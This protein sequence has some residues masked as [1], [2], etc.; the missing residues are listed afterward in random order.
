M[1]IIKPNNN[2]ISAITALPSGMT[3]APGLTTG[4]LVLLNTQTVSNVAEVFIVNGSSGVVFDNTYKSYLIK[5]IDCYGANDGVNMRAFIGNSSDYQTSSYRMMTFASRYNG[6]SE[7]QQNHYS[8]TKFF[9]TAQNVRNTS[10]EYMQFEMVIKGA[11]YSTRPSSYYRATYKNN[12]GEQ[13]VETGGSNYD[14]TTT[15]TKIKF[16]T[17][18]GNIYGTFSLYGI[19][20]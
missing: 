19:K 10:P 4:S 14:A 3:S 11:G 5:I 7:A 9:E 8:N 12:S 2:T 16:N 17:S 13:V 18:S 1:A 15:M 6:S 20:S